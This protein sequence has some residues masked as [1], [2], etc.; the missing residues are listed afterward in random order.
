MITC[1]NLCFTALPVLA[2]GVFD[3]DVGDRDSLSSPQLYTVGQCNSLFNMRIFVYSVLQG[4][5]R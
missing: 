4:M 1:Y 5:T 2:M 3:Q